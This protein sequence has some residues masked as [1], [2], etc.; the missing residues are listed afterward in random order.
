MGEGDS[1]LE[2]A[3]RFWSKAEENAQEE[4]GRT[5]RGFRGTGSGEIRDDR[6]GFMAKVVKVTVRSEKKED[7]ST[8]AEETRHG[9]EFDMEE[10]VR[11]Y[12]RKASQAWMMRDVYSQQGGVVW[13]DLLILTALQVCSRWSL[14]GKLNRWMKPDELY[15]EYVRLRRSDLRRLQEMQKIELINHQGGDCYV[16]DEESVILEA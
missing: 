12:L 5:V 1:R 15:T 4:S 2:F 14:A 7:A 3:W 11:K 13:R 8:K 6:F 10:A 16:G 9:L